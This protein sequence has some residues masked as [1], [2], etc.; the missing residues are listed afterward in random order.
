M[1]LPKL[2]RRVIGMIT[3][4]IHEWR[5]IV[6]EPEDI[7]SLYQ[8]YIVP[9]AAVPAVAMFIGLA[10]VGVPFVGRYPITTALSTAIVIFIQGLVAPIVVAIVVEQLAPKFKSRASTVDALKLVAYAST[11]MWVGG[12]IYVLLYLVALIIVPALY[13]VYLFYIGLTPILKTPADS[14]VPFMVVAAITLVVVNIFLRSLLWIFGLPYYG[15]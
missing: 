6:S 9:L 4:P 1:D 12:A 15:L 2:K 13:A 7:A 14:V 3:D 11:P 10:I 5:A 8:N